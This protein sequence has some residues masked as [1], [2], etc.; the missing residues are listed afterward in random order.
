MDLIAVENFKAVDRFLS[1]TGVSAAQDVYTLGRGETRVLL[2]HLVGE[3]NRFYF[4]RWEWIQLG[5]AV[6]FLFLLIYGQRPPKLAILLTLIMLT[7]LLGQRA[8][9]TPQ[10]SKIGRVLDFLPTSGDDPQRKLFWTFHGIYSG[11][12]LLKIALG[13]AIAGL[14]IVRPKPD[15]QMFARESELNEVPGLR[16]PR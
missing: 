2:R 3:Q 5:I 14:L 15:R 12:E 1:D 13:I 6:G 10:I 7:I 8:G 11:V 9:L 16:D 4:E